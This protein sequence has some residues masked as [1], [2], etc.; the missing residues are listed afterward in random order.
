VPA[1]PQAGTGAD[2]RLSV[3]ATDV[4]RESDLADYTGQLEAAQTLQITD[5]LN[6][7]ARG[8]M[9]DYVFRVAMPCT[10]TPSGSEGASCAVTTTANAV[11]PN[12]V[13]ANFRST[14]DWGQVRVFDGGPD[15]VASTQDNTLFLTQGVFVP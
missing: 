2:V 3:S 10:A 14:W 5:R 6:P 4:R 9:T 7:S 8:T 11:I 1:N 13:R 12:S 15:G